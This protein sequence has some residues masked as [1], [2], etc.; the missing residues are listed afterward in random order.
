MA[1]EIVCADFTLSAHSHQ[2]PMFPH[3]TLTLSRSPSHTPCPFRVKSAQ[4][5]P[6]LANSY[7]SAEELDD[8]NYQYPW[9][10][11]D[12]PYMTSWRSACSPATA[13]AVA[14]LSAEDCMMVD[15]EVNFDAAAAAEAVAT[16]GGPTWRES[17]GPAFIQAWRDACAGFD[18]DQRAAADAALMAVTAAAPLPRLSWQ[19]Q[20]GAEYIAAHR[21]AC[22]IESAP[23]PCR[24]LPSSRDSSLAA[25]ADMLIPSVADHAA[26]A[27]D[28][29]STWRSACAAA[30][31]HEQQEQQAPATWHQQLAQDFIAAHQAACSTAKAAAPASTPT[32]LTVPTHSTT[33][34][35]SSPLLIPSRASHAALGAAYIST[36]RSVCSAAMGSDA[37]PAAISWKQQLGDDCVAAH[38]AA[39]G[40]QQPALVPHTPEAVAFP[41]SN[42]SSTSSA[43]AVPHAPSAACQAALG[44]S[45]IATWR[46]A[47][48]SATEPAPTWQGQ[49]CNAYGA[50]WRGACGVPVGD[51]SA[52]GTEPA[53]AA[54]PTAPVGPGAFATTYKARVAQQYLAAY[55]SACA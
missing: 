8:G 35:S 15:A 6:A 48:S 3:C 43:S 47:C 7:F 13:P 1:F 46:G 51:L 39:C 55:R 9:D 38:R 31:S 53:A 37:A 22:G 45:F 18:A 49:V 34:A 19:Q 29:I 26:F 40:I 11:E 28:F 30:P 50:A 41:L 10:R 2:R 27:A 36:W 23:A 54:P 17:L 4:L 44:S 12:E 21:A 25:A 5:P 14:L 20:L 52:L 32:H 42:A 16:A 33:Q 24:P